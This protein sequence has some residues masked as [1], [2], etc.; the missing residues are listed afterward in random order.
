VVH[1]DVWLP[2]AAAVALVVD[3]HGGEPA[4]EP[5]IAGLGGR[6]WLSRLAT[7]WWWR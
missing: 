7:R 4:G 2:V 5:V 6:S 3:V 1:P